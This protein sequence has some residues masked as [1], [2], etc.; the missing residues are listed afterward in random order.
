MQKR[1]RYLCELLESNEC[2]PH[3]F[4]GIRN[5]LLSNKRFTEAKESACDLNDSRIRDKVLK[6]FKSAVVNLSSLNNENIDIFQDKL[7]KNFGQVLAIEKNTRGQSIF[8]QWHEE[9]SLP[10]TS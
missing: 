6:S 2:Q 8:T 4:E 3:R 1:A 10:L 7:G 9:R 5:S